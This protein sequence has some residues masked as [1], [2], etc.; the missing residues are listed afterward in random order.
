MKKAAEFLPS[1]FSTENKIFIFMKGSL[2]FRKTSFVRHWKIID[3][4]G[5]QI[6]GMWF[7]FVLGGWRMFKYS[8]TTE[9]GW[10]ERGVIESVEQLKGLLK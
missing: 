1:E 2:M 9:F 7:K 4:T 3:S 8:D 6:G 10:K 5:K